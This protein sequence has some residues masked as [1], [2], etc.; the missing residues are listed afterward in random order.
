MAQQKMIHQAEPKTSRS[1]MNKYINSFLKI[2]YRA[3]KP[4]SSVLT[5]KE[6]PQGLGQPSTGSYPA[7]YLLLV[8]AVQQSA[9]VTYISTLF[10]LLSHLGHYRA[11]S[12]VP[13]AIQQALISH[14]FY[15]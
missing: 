10:K 15:I 6:V 14:L 12:R 1:Q 8:S 4:I 5:Q 3:L 9:S 7:I 13:W 11:L 2:V